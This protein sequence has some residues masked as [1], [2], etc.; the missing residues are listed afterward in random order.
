MEIL[1]LISFLLGLG[2]LTSALIK[3]YHFEI[4][5]SIV[6]NKKLSGF[7]L[8][9]KIWGGRLGPVW[10]LPYRIDRPAPNDKATIHKNK[11]NS[12]SKIFRAFWCATIIWVV[13]VLIVQ[14]W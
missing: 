6:N 13:T 12:W 10:I 5:N 11:F 2:L 8:I 7:S 14:N 3:N 9:M 1:I 4:F